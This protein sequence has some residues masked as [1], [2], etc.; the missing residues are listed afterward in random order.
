[1][2]LAYGG[3]GAQLCTDVKLFNTAEYHGVVFPLT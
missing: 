3:G 1:M 2:I